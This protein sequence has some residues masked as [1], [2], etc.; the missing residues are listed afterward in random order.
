MNEGL[1]L[2]QSVELYYRYITMDR[3]FEALFVAT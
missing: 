1:V 3:I 2:N